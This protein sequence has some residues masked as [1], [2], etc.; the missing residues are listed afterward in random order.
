MFNQSALFAETGNPARDYNIYKNPS[1]PFDFSRLSQALKGKPEN[2]SL[3]GY[4]FPDTYFVNQ[5]EQPQ[6]VL[7]KIIQNFNKKVSMDIRLKIK[8]SGQGMHEI[9]TMASMLE[10]EATSTSYR[11][12]ISGILWKRLKI[13]MALQVDPT[14]R[15]ATGKFTGALSVD[16]YKFDSLFN[17]YKYRGLPPGPISNPGLD[18]IEAAL[19]PTSTSYFYYLSGKSGII[20]YAKTFEEHKLNKGRY[21][22]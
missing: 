4:I 12:I 5:N 15:Y 13:G 9:L 2:V 18:A 14:V 3:E 10:E 21:L 1:R 19:E 11:K 7:A 17:T 16:D 6:E 22:K 20:H 8:K